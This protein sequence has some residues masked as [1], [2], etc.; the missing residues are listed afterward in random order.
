[1]THISV[2][3]AQL[4][5]DLMDDAV[6]TG[7]NMVRFFALPVDTQYALQSRPGQF[8][9]AAFRGLDYALESARA[10]G[11]KVCGRTP[12]CLVHHD[13]HRMTAV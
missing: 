9:E 1:M 12:C 8:N 3:G 6:A 11:I 4:I 10:R 5:R 2:L 13:L 7:L